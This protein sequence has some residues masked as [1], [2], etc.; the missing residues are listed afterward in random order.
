MGDWAGV[1]FR[2]EVDTYEVFV[3]GRGPFPQHSRLTSSA[4]SLHSSYFWVSPGHSTALLAA[5]SDRHFCVTVKDELI[6]RANFTMFYSG[7]VEQTS[8]NILKT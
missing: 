4:R 1:G 8:C 3:S 7:V 5:F 6:H 2:M